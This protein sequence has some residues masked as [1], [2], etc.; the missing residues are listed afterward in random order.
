[1]PYRVVNDTLHEAPAK[2]GAS[3]YEVELWPHQSLTGNG[4]VWVV[5]ASLTLISL[6]ILGLLGTK[7]LWGILP[8]ALGVIGL[9]WF[10]LKRNWR[11]RDILETLTLTSDIARLVRIDPDGTRRDWQAN[12][13]WVRITRHE[14]VG[15]IE[16]YLT[17]EGG[18]RTVE[19]GAF[20]TPEE[21]RTL[22]HNLLGA[23]GRL[24]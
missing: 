9:L 21:R 16:D 11:D 10:S 13:Y 19:I 4:F 17:L 20:L 5:G 6:P 7:A 14:K 24:K 3:R 22:E 8:F 12:P 18:P 1:M 2:S 15:Q 23:L